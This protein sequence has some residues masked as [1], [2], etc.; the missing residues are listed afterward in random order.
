[1]SQSSFVFGALIAAFVLF[2][3]ARGRLP[4]YASV[5]WGPAP[6]TPQPPAQESDDGG[7][8]GIGSVIG[9]AVG[10]VF[11]GGPAGGAIGAQI[12]GTID[13]AMG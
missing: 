1:M 3:A 2:I 13:G 12:G 4:V 6:A 8:G 7:G 5:F 11:G 9:G 10:T